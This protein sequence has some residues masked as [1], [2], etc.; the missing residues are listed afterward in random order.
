MSAT[1]SSP[2]LGVARRGLIPRRPSDHSR[3]FVARMPCGRQRSPP[4]AV[5]RTVVV[6][7]RATVAS[8]SAAQS[9]ALVPRL[10]GEADLDARPVRRSGPGPLPS[11][12]LSRAVHLTFETTC[13]C[14]IAWKAIARAR[15]L[16]PTDAG[17]LWAPIARRRTRGAR[18]EWARDQLRPW[19]AFRS[20]A[21]AAAAAFGELR[22]GALATGETRVRVDAVLLQW[23]DGAT[24]G[25]AGLASGGRPLRTPR[26]GEPRARV[27][28]GAAAPVLVGGPRR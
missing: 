14:S 24:T 7:G 20:K 18:P 6:D 4:R 1:Y 16:L 9:E 13:G 10:S 28:G 21:G 27:P 5:R 23:K 11:I 17:A 22:G 19:P 12:A 8:R 25:G 15:L 26:W 3:A 2:R